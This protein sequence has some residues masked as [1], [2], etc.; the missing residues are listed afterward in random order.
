[1][2]DRDAVFTSRVWEAFFKLQGMDLKMSSAHHLQTDGQTERVNQ[3]LETYLRCYVQSAPKN[4]SKWLLLAEFWNNTAFHSALGN[5]TFV[6][7]YGQEPR[8]LGITAD[9]A[10]PMPKLNSCL[11][12]RQLMQDMLSHHLVQAKQIMKDQADKK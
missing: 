9:H 11:E 10:T 2:C 5:T 3:C 8:R 6:V 12:K 1:M 7:M 4:L